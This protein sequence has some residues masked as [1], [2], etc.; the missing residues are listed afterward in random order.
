MFKSLLLFTVFFLTGL[1]LGIY[2]RGSRSFDD[3]FTDI[4]SSEQSR[5]SLITEISQS[6][7]GFTLKQAEIINIISAYQQVLG[8]LPDSVVSPLL[9]QE[10]SDEK[11]AS[12]LIESKPALEQTFKEFAAGLVREYLDGLSDTELKSFKNALN[13]KEGVIFDKFENARKQ[14]ILDNYGKDAVES[15]LLVKAAL[16]AKKIPVPASL[17]KETAALQTEPN[18]P[19]AAPGAAVAPK[20]AA[21]PSGAPAVMPTSAGSPKPV[22]VP[23][24]VTQAAPSVPVSKPAAV[25]PARPFAPPVQAPVSPVKH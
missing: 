1:V 19:V 18:Q 10:M 21:A 22:V 2:L 13:E 9:K 15:T 12:F 6:K 17:E 16:E 11:Y 20:P 25:A 3:V 5:A 14:K 7:F 23:A 4:M 24:Q 8:S